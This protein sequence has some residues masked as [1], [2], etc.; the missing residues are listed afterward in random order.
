MSDEATYQ[1]PMLSAEAFPAR[2]SPLPD[3]ARDW[4]ESEA[5]YG[6]SSF[7]FLRKLSR[8]GVLSKMSPV[9][10]PA[11][12]EKILPSSFEGWSSAGMASC[13]GYWTLSISELPNDAAVCSL[14]EVL[15]A[16]APQQS[17]ITP[18]ENFYLRLKNEWFRPHLRIRAQL[19]AAEG[20]GHM[21]L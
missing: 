7:A 16:D 20:V 17:Y 8:A 19:T 3:A 15:E 6:S 9:F 21:E 11:T 14:S 4:L 5:D 18:T 2:M 12:A 1:M 10:Y 13:G